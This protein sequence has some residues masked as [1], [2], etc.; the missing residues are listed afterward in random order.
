MVGQ[1]GRQLRA[2]VEDVLRRW[3]EADV[4]LEP[5]PSTKDWLLSVRIPYESIV[6]YDRPRAGQI[7]RDRERLVQVQ[8]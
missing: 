1:S 3:P 2:T 6:L 4:E 8:E 7:E 5:S